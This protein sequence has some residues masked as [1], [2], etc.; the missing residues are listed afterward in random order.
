MS[1]YLIDDVM[2]QFAL[3]DLYLQV[4]ILQVTELQVTSELNWRIF[5]KKGFASVYSYDGNSW[6]SRRISLGTRFVILNPYFHFQIYIHF[7]V[8]NLYTKFIFS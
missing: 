8:A 4:N 2:Y 1:V 7:I 5:A 3:D 6:L